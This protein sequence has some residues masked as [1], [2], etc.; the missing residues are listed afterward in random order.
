MKKY[1]LHVFCALSISFPTHSVFAQSA[2]P[3]I[4]ASS[5]G[6]FTGGNHSMSWTLGEPLTETYSSSNNYLTQGFQQPFPLVLSVNNFTAPSFLIYPNPVTTNLQIDFSAVTGFFV[7]ELFDAQ[8]QLLLKKEFSSKQHLLNIDF[9]DF[10]QGIYL[11]N[12][13]GNNYNYK[14]S[15][16]IV[17]M[18]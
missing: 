2:A 3:E 18:E 1:L 17:K 8:G 6:F 16:K 9:N 12:I 7:V 4:I 11:V 13:S 10:A 14:G 15:Y 5:G